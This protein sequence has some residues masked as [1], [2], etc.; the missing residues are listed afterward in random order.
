MNEM[1]E[2]DNPHVPHIGSLKPILEMWRLNNSIKETHL[3]WE[4]K[5]GRDIVPHGQCPQETTPADGG[6]KEG[7]HSLS[8]ERQCCAKVCS[9]V[10]MCF[11]QTTR[12]R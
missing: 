7:E 11:P 10:D 4:T 5:T 6:G 8:G 9:L 2:T 3:P 1:S 12:T